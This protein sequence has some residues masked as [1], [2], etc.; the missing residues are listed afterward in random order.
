MK[1][2]MDFCPLLGRVNFPPSYIS[3]SSQNTYTGLQHVLP[4]LALLILT[5]PPFLTNPPQKASLLKRPRH[6]RKFPRPSLH[7][8]RRLLHRILNRK[9]RREH[10]HSHLTRLRHLDRNRPRCSSHPPILEHGQHMGTRR[11]STRRWLLRN[12][13]LRNPHLCPKYAL[14]WNSNIIDSRWPLQRQFHRPSMP[15]SSRRCHR[16]C[17]FPRQRWIPLRCLQNRR[18][19]PWRRRYLR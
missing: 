14:R 12:V 5:H 7:Q 9:R 11:R 6:H 10:S 8:R 19:F 15:N 16:P 18:Q 1:Y 2:K 3:N 13:L 17:R 4:F